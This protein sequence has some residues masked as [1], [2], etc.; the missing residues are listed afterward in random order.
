ME[1]V[2]DYDPSAWPDGSAKLILAINRQ[3]KTVTTGSFQFLTRCRSL[4][5][6]TYRQTL[7]KISRY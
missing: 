3:N 4:D 2:M 5:V 1:Y 7:N 6:I